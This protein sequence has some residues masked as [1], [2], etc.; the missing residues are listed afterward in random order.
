MIYLSAAGASPRPTLDFP[1]NNIF[2]RSARL[3]SE[4]IC[5]IASERNDAE[6][7]KMK[8]Q[9]VPSQVETFVDAASSSSNQCVVTALLSVKKRYASLPRQWRSPKKDC[10]C[11]ENGKKP[12]GT[13]IPTLIP[14]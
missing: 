4:A 5:D 9:I 1:K 6:R 3:A 10:L 14:T 13:G 12:T 2:F 11:P 7:K 8:N